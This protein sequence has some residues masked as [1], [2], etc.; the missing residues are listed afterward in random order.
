MV[1]HAALGPSKR[2]G[3]IGGSR[4]KGADILLPAG[5]LLRRLALVPSSCCLR[6]AGKSSGPITQEKQQMSQ[7]RV[8]ML[9][10]CTG[11]KILRG[12]CFLLCPLQS[13]YCAQYTRFCTCIQDERLGLLSRVSCPLKRCLWSQQNLSACKQA[14]TCRSGKFFGKTTR[15]IS[16]LVTGLA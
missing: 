12:S 5:V 8:F 15:V 2:H 9:E 10:W 4:R 6:A 11:A 14:L 13:F 7:G 3:G 1:S 16:W